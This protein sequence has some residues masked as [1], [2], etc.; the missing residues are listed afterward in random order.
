MKEDDALQNVISGY[1]GQVKNYIAQ[2]ICRV[3]KK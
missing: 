1:L 3:E 2:N